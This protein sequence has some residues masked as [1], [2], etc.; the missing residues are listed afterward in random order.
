MTS[1]YRSM[2]VRRRQAEAK[3]SH[4]QWRV[5]DHQRNYCHGQCHV[6]D[7]QSP[8]ECSGGAAFARAQWRL[9]QM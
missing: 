5:L 6:P 3:L 7:H 1:L 9:M 4:D 2:M 8:M